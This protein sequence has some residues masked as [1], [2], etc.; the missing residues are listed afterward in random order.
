MKRPLVSL[1]NMIVLSLAGKDFFLTK[2]PRRS[3]HHNEIAVK[4]AEIYG[5]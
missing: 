2:N 5:V 4:I 3:V 1:Y